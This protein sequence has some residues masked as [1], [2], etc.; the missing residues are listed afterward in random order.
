VSFY[1]PIS[2]H[3][4]S[5]WPLFTGWVA[6]SEYRNHR[7][8]SAYAHLMQNADLTWA[9]DLGGVTELLSGEFFR[10]FGRSTS[11]QLWSSAMVITPTLRGMF[12][13]EWDAA[14]QKLN[15]DPQLPAEWNSAKLSGVPIADKRVGI[16]LQRMRDMLA[17][18]LTGE[19]AQTITL[20]SR[21][22]GARMQRGELLIPLPAVEV[23][24]A[25]GLPEFGSMTSQMKVLEQRATP[26]SLSLKLAA[27]ASSSQRLF[28]RV[29][30][31][32]IHLRVEGAD[33]PDEDS[34]VAVQFPPGDGYIEKEVTLSW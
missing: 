6:L 17:I 5:V 12:G 26:R 16:E 2:Y 13:L 25:H 3:Q 27:P 31:P 32:N 21:S 10:W 23:G 9:Q 1:D 18:R 33:P 8:L 34:E 11:H 29:N 28:V 4:G 22:A 30:R 19:G 7:A 20:A 15:V 24:I 14:G